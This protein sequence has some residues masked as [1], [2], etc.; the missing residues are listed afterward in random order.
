MST[1]DDEGGDPACWA[2]LLEDDAEDEPATAPSRPP[3]GATVLQLSDTHLTR[4]PGDEVQGAD[5]L[6]RLRAVLD[7]W[8]RTGWTADLVLLTGDN[9]DDGSVEGY[10]RLHEAL[11]PLGA[12]VLAVAGNHDD[13]VTQESVLGPATTAE[14][15]RWRV[16]GLTSAVPGQIHGTI[17]AAAVARQLDGLDDRP[18]VVAIHHPPHSRSTHEW[19]RLDGGDE[20]LAV[21][22]ARPHV[23]LLVSGHLHDA[24][25]LAGPGDLA[26]LGAPS[27]LVA[28]GHDGDRFEIGVDAPAGARALH[29]ADDG[30]FTTTLLDT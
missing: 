12:P 26:L 9:T 14:V 19:F 2:H 18:T 4:T 25:E 1:D 15:G 27:A 11:L 29:L 16:V 28:I 10:R 23:R 5:P 6:R 24:F 21:L 3:A 20:L 30:T 8:R 13:R 17:D 7:R 22:G